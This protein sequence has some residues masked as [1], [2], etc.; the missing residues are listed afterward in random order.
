MCSLSVSEHLPLEHEQNSLCQIN[1]K[2]K[3]IKY[4]YPMHMTLWFN[5]VNFNNYR[6]FIIIITLLLQF[7]EN[8]YRIFLFNCY[9]EPAR[10]IL[11]E[12]GI[13]NF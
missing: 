11:C 3:V 5:I 6:N 13:I 12:V 4:D 9:S 7:E 1:I 2:R 10:Q 8:D